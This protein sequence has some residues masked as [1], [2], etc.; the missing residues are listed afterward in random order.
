M[1]FDLETI[2]K[3]F[4]NCKD[5]K[6]YKEYADDINK[7]NGIISSG[8]FDR[9]K[10]EQ[11]I[12]ELTTKYEKYLNAIATVFN[13]GMKVVPVVI[14][15]KNELQLYNELVYVKN[16]IPLI[17]ICKTGESEIMKKL[18]GLS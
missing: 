6:E 1:T 17:A 2:Y 11:L 15:Q 12:A 3:E 16:S 10:A 9:N 5:L 7:I 13:N 8:D 18:L 4:E 14:Q